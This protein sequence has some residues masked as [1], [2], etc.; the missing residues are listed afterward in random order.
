MRSAH[1]LFRRR[2]VRS[3]RFSWTDEADR[4]LLYAFMQLKILF[5]GGFSI[6]WLRSNEQFLC[7]Y[8]QPLLSVKTIFSF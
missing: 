4:Y 6:Q 5:L 3:Q 1:G 7:C 8:Y 2:P